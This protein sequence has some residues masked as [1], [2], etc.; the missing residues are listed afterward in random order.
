MPFV[1]EAFIDHAHRLGLQVH[2]WTVNDP[3]AITRLLDLGIDG[4]MTDDLQT[5]RRIMTT[6]DLWPTLAP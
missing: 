4:I 5:L 3:A 1:T 2:A 6:R